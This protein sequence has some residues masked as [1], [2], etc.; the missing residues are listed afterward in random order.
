MTLTYSHIPG[1]ADRVAAAANVNLFHNENHNLD[2]KA[3]AA[4][5]MPAAAQFPNSNTYG[6]GAEY[7]YCTSEFF[8]YIRKSAV[9]FESRQLVRNGAYFAS[10]RA[11]PG[12]FIRHLRYL[13]P[14]RCWPNPQ[15]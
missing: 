6:A 14:V 2:A 1:A 7:M 9:P 5:T 8:G 3:F 15:G 10:G 12:G 13:V 4:H 11:A